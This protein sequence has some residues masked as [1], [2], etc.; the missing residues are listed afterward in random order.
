M[1]G[2]QNIKLS[3]LMAIILSECCNDVFPH[4]VFMKWCEYPAA[5][6]SRIFWTV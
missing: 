3:R 6:E 1:H 2:Q 4:S 5:Y